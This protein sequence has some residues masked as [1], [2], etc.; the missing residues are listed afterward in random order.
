[1]SRAPSRD[2]YQTRAASRA[3]SRHASRESSL[4]R[5]TEV[6]MVTSI[7]GALPD[8]SVEHESSPTITQ[9]TATQ[10][11]GI[12]DIVNVINTLIGAIGERFDGMEAK[13]SDLQTTI[14]T[15]KRDMRKIISELGERQTNQEMTV[16]GKLDAL[17]GKQDKIEKENTRD[18]ERIQKAL[19]GIQQQYDKIREE[20]DRAEKTVT[21]QIVEVTQAVNILAALKEP[22]SESERPRTPVF[23]SSTPAGVPGGGKGLERSTERHARRFRIASTSPDRI[24]E[25]TAERG[26]PE[27][28]KKLDGVFDSPMKKAVPVTK[29]RASIGNTTLGTISTDTA[30]AIM[31]KP[32][33]YD[34]K[35]G[36]M[37]RSFIT[38]METYFRTR[39]SQWGDEEKIYATLTNIGGTNTTLSWAL[40]LLENYNNGVNHP[41][42]ENW[43]A[44]KEAFLLNFDDPTYAMKANEELL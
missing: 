7:P 20:Q 30:K 24:S 43:T 34:G 2:P 31:K 40:P 22:E 44:F 6:P 36:L 12:P 26:R 42:L 29:T 18:K 32:A 28:R 21:A 8:T 41:Y 14:G 33:E 13:I 10:D 37:A 35:R 25:R 1:M 38:K 23:H 5:E 9:G 3:A 19:G 39:D 11:V 16:H 4:I 15:T 17:Y 27:V